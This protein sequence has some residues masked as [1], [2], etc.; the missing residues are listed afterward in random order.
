MGTGKG[1]FQGAGNGSRAG[2]LLVAMG[3][4][5]G[6]IVGADCSLHDEL[7]EEKIRWVVDAARRI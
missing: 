1:R 2:R 3:G 4:K 7:P 5:S 6:Y